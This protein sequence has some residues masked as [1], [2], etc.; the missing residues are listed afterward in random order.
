[1]FL[2]PDEISDLTGYQPQSVSHQCKWLDRH[3][4][5]FELSAAGRPKV[6]RVY[7]ERRLGLASVALKSESEPDF[8]QWEK[9]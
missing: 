2:T 6:L 9:R 7:V 4:F 5:P 3:G 8:S 1:M